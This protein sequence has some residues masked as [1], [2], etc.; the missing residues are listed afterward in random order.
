MGEKCS[1]VGSTLTFES[2]QIAPPDRS[3]H[4]A[5]SSADGG[6]AVTY[7]GPVT[8]PADIAALLRRLDRAHPAVREFAWVWLDAYRRD[9]EAVLRAAAREQRLA[10]LA[11]GDPAASQARAEVRLAVARA[12]LAG[13]LRRLLDWSPPVP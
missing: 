1:I 9:A 2:C 13:R 5:G 3:G 7:G 4:L 8:P 11:H 12:R 6:R 10:A